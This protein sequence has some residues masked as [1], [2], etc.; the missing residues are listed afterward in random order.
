[1]VIDRETVSTGS[2]N[3][4]KA[5]EER[6]AENLRIIKS[7]DLAKPF[8]DDWNRHK[9]QAEVYQ[10]GIKNRRIEEFRMKKK[11]AILTIVAVVLGLVGYFVLPGLL[12]KRA[13][14]SER[15]TAGLAQK[16]VQVGDHEIIYLEGG[17]GETILLLHGFGAN[18]DNW[19]RFAKFISPAYHVVALDLPGFGES[20]CREDASYRIA[21]Q[22]KRLTQF[23]DAI[24]LKKFHIL[25]NSMGGHIAARYTVMFPERVLTLGL[26]DSGGVRSPIPSELVKRLSRGE[27]NPLVAGSVEEYDQLIKFVFSTPP[28]IPTFVKRL[29]V[30]EAQ[31]HKAS[32][33][34]IFQQISNENMALEPD[35]PKIKTRTLVL[36][37][38]QDRV[39]DVSSVPILKKGLSNSTSVIM[40]NCGHVPMIERPKEAAEHYLRFLKST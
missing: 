14:D 26:F 18:K 22:A 28:E 8:I 37:G 39:I 25:G 6:N 13:T 34:R 7:K 32:N 29:L 40:H 9:G 33:Q 12:K 2:F 30:E 17:H 36:W 27:P 16:R 38:D 11:L 31:K 1:M 20:T 4:T 15:K 3:F 21:D 35:L 23:A 19:T 24:G 5:A 10:A